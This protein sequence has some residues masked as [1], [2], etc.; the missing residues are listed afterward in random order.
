[1]PMALFTHFTA[2]QYFRRWHTVGAWIVVERKDALAGGYGLFEMYLVGRRALG[3]ETVEHQNSRAE[4]V[5]VC[6][7]TG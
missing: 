1:M 6:W 3:V 7:V 5:R 2:Q 4:T